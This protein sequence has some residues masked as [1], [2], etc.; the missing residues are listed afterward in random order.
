VDRKLGGNCE[1]SKDGEKGGS[2]EKTSEIIR[3]KRRSIRKVAAC[4]KGPAWTV[5]GKFKALALKNAWIGK[6]TGTKIPQEPVSQISRENRTRM[7]ENEEKRHSKIC[8]NG[9]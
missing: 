9:H 4:V 1:A 7:D 8:R 5:F 2:K 3:R 6:R